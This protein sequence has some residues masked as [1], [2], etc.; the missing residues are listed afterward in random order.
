MS[1]LL[2]RFEALLG[3]FGEP[4]VLDGNPAQAWVRAVSLGEA[5]I[6]LANAVVDAAPR[7]IRG[8]LFAEGAA[9]GPGSVVGWLG[10]DHEVA[11]VR[12]YRLSGQT[13][14]QLALAWPVK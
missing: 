10:E 3:A 14:A 8:F 6:W 7:P 13:L 11:F 5:R 9:V 12:P 2:E 4:V 1:A